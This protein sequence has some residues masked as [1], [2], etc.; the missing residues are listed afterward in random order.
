A[1]ALANPALQQETEPQGNKFR[2]DGFQVTVYYAG[3][4][5]SENKKVMHQVIPFAL[6]SL[7]LVNPVVIDGV[8]VPVY[9]HVSK[10]RLGIRLNV[11][12]VGQGQGKAPIF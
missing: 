12:R 3:C 5:P 2:K 10:D 9:E 11:A 8:E 6:D 1:E 4:R 7:P